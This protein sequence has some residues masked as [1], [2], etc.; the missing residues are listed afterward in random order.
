MQTDRLKIDTHTNRQINTQIDKQAH[1]PIFTEINK[2]IDRQS[3]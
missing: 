1:V 3:N 2:Q